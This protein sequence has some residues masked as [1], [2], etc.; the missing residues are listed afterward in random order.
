MMTIKK[1]ITLEN[2]SSDKR[3]TFRGEFMK[4]GFKYNNIFWANATPIILLSNLQIINYGI[5]LPK[6]IWINLTK[7]FQSLGILKTGDKVQ[8]NSK[9]YKYKTDY[10]GYCPEI[11]QNLKDDYRIFHPSKITLVTKQIRTP[12]EAENH[13]I[14]NHIYSI[15]QDHYV[16]RGVLPPYGDFQQIKKSSDSI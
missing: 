9:L 11:I 6:P 12:W 4:Y 2:I 5:S 1:Q 13:E 16:K 14:C 10:Q 3:L 15:Y 8:F 7:G